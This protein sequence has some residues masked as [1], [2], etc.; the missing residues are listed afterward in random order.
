MRLGVPNIRGNL[1]DVTGRVVAITGAGQGIGRALAEGFA[2]AGAKTVLVDMNADKLAETGGMIGGNAADSAQVVADV[3]ADD[4]PKRIV[5]AC[6]GL[7]GRIDCLIN[8]AGIMSY[9]DARTIADDE[10]DRMIS[11]NLR[12]PVRIM[13]EVLPVMAEQGAG[14]VINIGSSWT[15]S[16]FLFKL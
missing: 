13:R 3:S 2:S 12:A 16:S 5:D 7:G 1:F 6:T 10:F 11:I 15:I 14:S 8:N 9:T 4:A